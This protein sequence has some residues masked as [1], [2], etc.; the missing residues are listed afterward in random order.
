MTACQYTR[1]KP[2]ATARPGAAHRLV[3]VLHQE[4][5]HL[6][7]TARAVRELV[8]DARILI[9]DVP[10]PLVPAAAAAAD[11]EPPDVILVWADPGGWAA[12]S[13][14]A[15]YR[16]ARLGPPVDGLL[17]AEGP[18]EKYPVLITDF[19]GLRLL[20]PDAE[21][22]AVIAGLLRAGPGKAK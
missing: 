10:A 7:A 3:L 5:G 11:A 22:A 21:V 13:V 9:L 15:A 17:I 20:P 1:G 12:A 6:D 18:L 4:P 19:P 14:L 16:P 8:P 2:G